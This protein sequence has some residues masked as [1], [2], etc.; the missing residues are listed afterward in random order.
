MEIRSFTILLL[1]ALL[2]LSAGCVNTGPSGGSNATI[3]SSHGSTNVTVSQAT[4]AVNA[5]SLTPED[6]VAFVNE[7]AVYAQKV[8]K[9][10]AL[11]EFADRNGSFTRGEHFVWAYN[12]NTI[13]L[14]NPYHPEFTGHDESNK[15]DADGVRMQA[16]MQD[17]A[18]NG[19]GFITYRFQDPLTGKIIPKLAYLKKI[20]D[21]WWIGSSIP[22]T[23]F[24]IPGE[25]PE[26]VR[27][28][29]AAKVDH[30]AA[31]ARDSGQAPALAEFNNASSPFAAEGRYIFAFDMNGTTIAMPFMKENLLKNE[32]NST[33][34]NGVALG[35][36]EIRLTAQGG[37]YFY[38]VYT[39]P[40]S[41]KPEFKVSYVAPVDSS[42]GVGAG[43]YLPDVPAVFPQ[44]QRDRLVSRVGE[45]AAYVKKNGRDAAVREFNDPNGS[46]SQPEMFI[47]AYDRNGTMLANPSI[48]GMVGVNRLSD[49][50][51]YGEYPVPYILQNAENGGGFLYYFTTDPANNYQ[52]RLNLG[53]SQMAGDDL[54]VGAGIFP[55]GK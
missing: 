41:N 15:T 38:Y 17:A 11:R 45:A 50:D 19:S 54:V 44:E 23:D 37:G 2:I 9:P 7:A 36:Q 3:T 12:F 47:F 13:N 22:G 33:D 30:A 35:E 1:A 40:D 29:L 4:P 49:R 55:Q 27:Q 25:S 52:L 53:Y 21:T 48:P 16:R 51:P 43:K 39:N 6:L 26:L 10:A 18:R 24:N 5:T 8:G 28:I 32:R 20:D 14:G 46:F 31:F 34:Q 42:W